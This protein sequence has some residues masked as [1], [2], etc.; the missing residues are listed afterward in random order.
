MKKRAFS[1]ILFSLLLLLFLILFAFLCICA[2]YHVSY[3]PE[4]CTE[5]ADELSNPYIGFYSMYGYVLGN[6][7]LSN[8]PDPDSNPEETP[9]LV[10]LELNL[11]RF[12]D[13]DLSDPALAQPQP[14]SAPHGSDCCNRKPLH[15][16][17]FSD[18]GHFCR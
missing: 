5:S 7:T 4:A 15:G 3:T 17:C 14:D 11:R 8:L 16:Q 18:P 10:M 6:D 2:F 1:R 12:A 13:Q 9:G